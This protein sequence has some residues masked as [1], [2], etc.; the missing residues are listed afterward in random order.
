M[1]RREVGDTGEI[2]VEAPK[3]ARQLTHWR[4]RKFR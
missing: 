2:H 1:V 4:D 3:V